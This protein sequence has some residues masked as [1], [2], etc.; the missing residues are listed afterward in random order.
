MTKDNARK[1]LA[2]IRCVFECV[3]S[4][5]EGK[6]FPDAL[7]FVP[8]AVEYKFRS[9]RSTS[10]VI[11]DLPTTS[12]AEIGEIPY[13][14]SS[15]FSASGEE[16]WSDEG[17]WL[18]LL[19]ESLLKFIGE[20]TYSSGWILIRP[21]DNKTKNVVD[22]VPAHTAK[23]FF[24]SRWED[25][26]DNSYS[27]KI[28]LNKKTLQRQA[29]LEAMKKLKIPP[30]NWSLELDE[31]LGRFICENVN[32]QKEEAL[33]TLSQY[34]ESIE[35]SSQSHYVSALTDG[36]VETYWESDGSQGQHWIRLK[37]K[38]GTVV[39]QLFVWVNS[40]DDNYMP[41]RL[42]VHGG[43]TDNMNLLN[44][45]HV[46]SSK[47]GDVL[48]L[49]DASQHYPILQI[50]IK[51]CKDDGIDTRIHGIKIMSTNE[52][53]PGLNA[54]IFKNSSKITNY[55][56]LEHVNSESLYNRAKSLL[57][58]FALFDSI[59]SFIFPIWQFTVGSYSSLAA[60]RQLL[61]LS[62]R[63]TSLIEQLIIDSQS[64][65]T[66]TSIPQVV[67]NRHIAA[68]HR[69]N[70]ALDPS[71][72]QSMF[73]QLYEALSPEKCGV[74]LD[75]RWSNRCD[76]WWE[77]KFISEGIIDQGGGFRDSLCDL[78]EELCPSS[79]DSLLPLPFFIR[80][81]NQLYD[82][83]NVYRDGYIPNPSCQLFEHYKWLG[84]LMGGH[85]RGRE[86]FLL[87]FPKYVWKKILSEK[88]SWLE[89]FVTVD[90][91][92][93]KLVQSIKEMDK[94]KFSEKFADVLTYTAVLS[95]GKI[96][97][98]VC[99]G[100]EKVVRFEDRIEYAELLE[101]A[102]MCECDEQ[103][104][105]IRHGLT[106][107]VPVALLD[108]LTWQELELKVC[109]N[110]KVDVRDLRKT[111]H[112]E[113]VLQSDDRVK[114]FWKAMENF[115]NEDRS[116]FLRFVTGRRRLPAH[117]TLCA[118]KSTTPIDSLPEAAT[119]SSTLFLPSYSSYLVAEEKL[120]YAAYNCVSIDTDGSWDEL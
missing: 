48:L 74:T 12:S 69:E 50:W 36:D 17:H 4:L 9:E 80:S 88:V 112:F 27:L 15:K 89:D 109:G 59:V 29:D 42:Q 10:V 24:P 35:V 55:P 1:R 111:T 71:A 41:S 104:N 45:V 67:L 66:L 108:L 3:E 86:N 77:C 23:K 34:V 114:Y 2:R 8:N 60:I 20:S 53:E 64:C 70:P 54:D 119:C 47:N 61:P 97:P 38:P 73:F 98:L 30:P 118:A 21:R 51:D 62:S 105:A 33:G 85:L 46:E 43:E 120:R 96:V 95:D 84:M 81:P 116:R 16:Y 103:I 113:D 110:P 39:K 37:M 93:V 7:C 75:F 57:R 28:S 101:V 92:L 63:R 19:P 49:E 25:V 79:P 14:L 76:Q 68:E 91:A 13:K 22:V 117:M 40:H 106:K 82:S 99:N 65:L 72:K 26:I 107:V 58:F 78:A 102:R 87:S 31:E 44:E 18:R 5:R 83:S 52:K 56:K 115:S 90:A 32:I 11:R 6:E 94:E 100:E